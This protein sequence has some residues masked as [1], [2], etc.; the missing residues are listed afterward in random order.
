MF[1]AA[2]GI[3]AASFFAIKSKKD[4]ADSPTRRERPRLKSRV[5]IHYNVLLLLGIHVDIQETLVNGFI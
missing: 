5:E 2:L 3:A 4:I 1:D